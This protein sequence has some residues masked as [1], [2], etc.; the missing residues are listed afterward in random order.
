MTG[1]TLIVGGAHTVV[2]RSGVG[3]FLQDGGEVSLRRL[4]VAEFG[5]S[6][7]STY[8]LNDGTLTL[9][10]RMEV[11]RHAAATF[12]QTGGTVN[13]TGALTTDDPFN[14]LVGAG[15]NAGVYNLQGGVLNVGLLQKGANGQFN[16]TG[17]R[18][19]AETV[20]FDLT[21]T[22]GTLAPGN[23]PGVT[24][25]NGN[26][27]QLAGG[28]FEVDIEGLDPGTGYDRLIVNGEVTLD[29]TLD[30][31]LGFAPPLGEEFI[32]IDNDGTSDPVHDQFAGLPEGSLVWAD[33][34]GVNYSFRLTY[35]GYDGNDVVLSSVPEPAACT[36]LAIGL[37]GL[38]G[39]G[40]RLRSRGSRKTA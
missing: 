21:N 34:L 16:F 15:S 24:T 17:G 22:G 33:Y 8:T 31:L 29:G 28:T 10:Q 26:Y 9:S 38:L 37:I 27:V 2:G 3:H 1:G 19:N 20:D 25:I 13:A 35:E 5:G 39:C 18:L 11:G 4:F 23:S 12:T 6:G 7:G 14:I 36:L 30:V 40:R 32:I